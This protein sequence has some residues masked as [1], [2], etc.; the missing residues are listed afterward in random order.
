MRVVAP[1]THGELVMKGTEM[2]INPGPKQW[3][4]Q[5]MSRTNTYSKCKARG[6][7]DQ[8][9]RGGFRSCKCRKLRGGWVEFEVKIGWR[10][11]EEDEEAIA[12]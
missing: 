7:A 8:D 6:G 11:Q 12:M 10:S 3:I 1:A 9:M 4:W 2:T 5:N